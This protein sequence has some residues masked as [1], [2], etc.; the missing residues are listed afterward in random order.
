MTDD[1]RR[2]AR[3]P[4]AQRLGLLEQSSRTPRAEKVARGAEASFVAAGR[5]R[6]VVAVREDRQSRRQ[7]VRISSRHLPVRGSPEAVAYD[8]ADEVIGGPVEAPESGIPA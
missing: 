3:T 8:M 6:D 2:S 5:H 1:E 7:A 4:A